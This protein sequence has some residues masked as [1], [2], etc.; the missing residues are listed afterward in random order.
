MSSVIIGPTTE[1]SRV[2]VTQVRPPQ[3]KAKG[4]RSCN[5]TFQIIL[6][7]LL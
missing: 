7:G 3:K 5:H 6:N 4:V 1:L 2:H